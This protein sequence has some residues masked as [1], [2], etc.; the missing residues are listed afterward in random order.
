MPEMMASDDWYRSAAW[1]EDAREEF[2]A[3][4]A[5][6]RSGRSQYLFIKGATLSATE[7]SKVREAGRALMMRSLDDHP[8]D[9]VTV[10]RVHHAI[11]G[12]YAKDGMYAEASKH[13]EAALKIEDDGLP[14][15]TRSD[16]E[17]AE[18]IVAAR[19]DGRYMEAR[20]WLSHF[21]RTNDPFAVTRFRAFLTEARIANRMGEDDAARRNAESALELLTVNRSPF[22]GHPDMGLIHTDK[23]TFRELERLARAAG[24]QRWRYPVI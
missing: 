3:R 1:D 22:T 23:A 15:T 10:I 16:L 4:V 7:D 21:W 19:W 5:R 11:A 8:D 9:M 20:S 18:L 17:L 24:E 14:V 6:A 12:A 2:E 13:Y